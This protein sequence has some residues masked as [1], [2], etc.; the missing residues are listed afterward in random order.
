[1]RQVLSVKNILHPH[2]PPP[3]KKEKK[4]K[5]KKEFIIYYAELERMPLN[6]TII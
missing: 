2:P 1:M 3:Q 4:K 6:V 5:R